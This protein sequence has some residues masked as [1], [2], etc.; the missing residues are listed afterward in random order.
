MIFFSVCFLISNKISSSSSTI[1]ELGRACLKVGRAGEWSSAEGIW[2]Y[3]WQPCKQPPPEGIATLIFSVEYLI[4]TRIGGWEGEKFSIQHVKCCRPASKQT[5]SK[6]KALLDE[7]LVAPSQLEGRLLTSIV[8]VIILPLPKFNSA[9]S[10]LRWKGTVSL[11]FIHYSFILKLLRNT[12]LLRNITENE[13]FENLGWLQIKKL[14]CFGKRTRQ[15]IW[16]H[17]TLWR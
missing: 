9:T 10:Q 4:L 15:K 16:R 5:W 7:L 13:Y 8:S 3:P 11:S 12:K 2:R 14:E 6:H 17:E 1:D